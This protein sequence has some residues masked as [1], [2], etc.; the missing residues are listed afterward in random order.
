MKIIGKGDPRGRAD[1]DS[2]E[3]MRLVQAKRYGDVEVA[4]RSILARN[5]RHTLALK[6]LSFALVAL[7]RDEE[8]L[9]IVDRALRLTPADGELHNN[10]G[11]ALSML[12]R[13]DDSIASFQ[14]AARRAPDDPEI[15]K[16]LGYA[17]FRMGRSDEAVAELL[18]AVEIHPGDYV[19]AIHM[20]IW[21]LMGA[22]R[23]DEAAACARALHANLPDD[24]EA[25]SCLIYIDLRYCDW[26]IVVEGISRLRQLS[27]DFQRPIG[28]VGFAL[29]MNGLGRKDLA[30]IAGNYAAEIISPTYLDAPNPLPLEWQPATRRLRIGYMSADFRNH[31]VGCAIA[32]LVERHDRQRIELFAYSLG[33]SDGSEVRRRLETAF[34][35]FIDSAPLSVHATARRVR[36]DGIDIL[37]DLTGWTEGGR[38]ESLAIR[39]APIQVNWLGYPG[40]LGH[41]KLAD[42]IIGDLVTTPRSAQDAYTETIRQM[43]NSYMPFDT[44]RAL[45]PPP[46]RQSQGL[47]DAAFVLCSFN[48]AY[49]F[50]PPLFD[51]WCGL[52]SE[53]PDAVLWLPQHSDVVAS[54]LRREMERRGIDAGRLLLARRVDS[55]EEHLN[56]LQLADLALDTFPYNSHSTGADALWA[57]VPMVAKLGDS[58]AARVGASLLTAAGLPELIAGD[59]AAYMRLVLEL[60]HDRPRLADLRQRLVAARSVAPLFDMQRFARDLEDLYFT[61]ADDALRAA[62]GSAAALPQAPATAS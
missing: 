14:E 25:L 28:N 43:P 31:A 3:L 33:E 54:N 48:N 36:D 61:M 17:W 45:G 4:A 46:S 26:S 2:V 34:E 39:C 7:G 30:A 40:T 5:G 29:P 52:L 38:L 56:R 60:Y 23:W 44:V 20:L 41:R 6:A 47:P 12:M 49:K 18:K 8:V 13:W 21:T 58:F 22:R 16:N 11:I 10:K 1:P 42:Y 51:L 35:H 62:T 32:E 37:V 53:M 9:P 19:E 24:P 59:D 57:G 15:H 27:A 50:N 55:R